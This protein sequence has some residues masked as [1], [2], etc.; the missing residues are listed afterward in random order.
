VPS[1]DDAAWRRAM[2]YLGRII[3]LGTLTR[4]ALA[5]LAVL[6]LI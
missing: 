6:V 1:Y 5:A 4:I 2:P 3:L